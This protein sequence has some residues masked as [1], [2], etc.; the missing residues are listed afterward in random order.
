MTD[1]YWTDYGTTNATTIM[2][3]T[4]TYYRYVDMYRD[5]Q[6]YNRRRQQYIN[7]SGDWHVEPTKNEKKA[8]E[9]IEFF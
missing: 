9:V 7:W 3:N 6:R 5:Q 4:T 8:E 1:Y 2:T